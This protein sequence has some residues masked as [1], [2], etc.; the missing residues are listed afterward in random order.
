M[1]YVLDASVALKGVFQEVDSA[2]ALRVRDEFQ[3]GVCE[4]IAPISS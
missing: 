2:N 4:L 3:R 1:K